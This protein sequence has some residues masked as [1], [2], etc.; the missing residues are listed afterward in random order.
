MR[1][2]V[3]G[4]GYVGLVTGACFADLGHAVTC[5]DCNKRK[6]SMLKK[7]KVPIFEPGLDEVIQRNRASGRL[8][9]TTDIA[10]PVRKS[11]FVFIAV[12]TPPRPNGEPDLSQVETAARS[13][14]KNLNGYK[15]IVNK[16]TVP[17]GMGDVVAG[18][19]RR[20]RGPRMRFSVVSNP[21]FLREGTAVYDFMNPDRIVIGSRDPKASEMVKH[22][23]RSLNATVTITDVRSAEMIK[24]ASNAFLACKISFIN[25]VSRLCERMGADVSEVARGMGQDKRIGPAF[26]QAGAGFGGSCF[27]KDTMALLHTGQREN[28]EMKLLSSVVQVNTDQKKF[29]VDKVRK[30]VGTLKGANIGVWGLAFKA[31]TDDMREA[32]SVDVIRALR[33]AGASIAAYDP[34]AMANARAFLPDIRYARD[35][36]DAVRGSDL[37]LVLTEWNE[38]KDADLRKVKSLLKHPVIVDGRNLYDPAE[39][40]RLGIT[41]LG[42]G[43]SSKKP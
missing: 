2:T 24:Y 6:V 14:A 25:E 20:L 16:S 10:K 26:L 19:I 39:M 13:I 1:I 35:M 3:I 36:Y 41:Y 21:E 8:S 12:G 43:R 22:L 4:T 9:F 11:N 30:A 38:F 18:I 17:V 42:V 29:M 7:G 34:A 40:R 28:E 15:I 32:V 31:N 33:S 23:Y 37:L 27:P 5:V